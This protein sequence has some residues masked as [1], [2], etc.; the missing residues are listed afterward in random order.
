[1]AKFDTAILTAAEVS[2]TGVYSC[3]LLLYF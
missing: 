3:H 2:L 1:L